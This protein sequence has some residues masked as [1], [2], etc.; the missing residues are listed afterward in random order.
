MAL[1]GA[2]LPLL[3]AAPPG[4]PGPAALRELGAPG[5]AAVRP[6]ALSAHVR[7]LSSDLLGGRGTATPGHAL[8]ELYVSAE[9]EAAGLEP[10]G[11]EG[12]WLQPVPLR[13]WR[14]DHASS[15]LALHG[16]SHPL[17]ALVPDEDFVL[18]SDGEHGEV[19]VDGPLAFA[20]YAVSAPEYGY[21]DLRG[22]DLRGKVAVVLHGAPLSERKNFFPPTAHALYSDRREKVRRL[23]E[24]GAVGVLF[25]HT[26]D[27]AESL[28]WED[29][30]RDSRTEGM[31]WLEGGRLG[32]GV[33]GV[34]ARGVLSAR[35][36]AKVLAAAGI[37]GGAKAVLEKAEANRLVPQEWMLRARFRSRAEMREARGANVLG[38]LRGSDPAL[39][40][41]VVVITA[42]LDHLGEGEPVGGDGIYNGAL[43]NASGVA[44]LIEAARAFAALPVR[45][46]RSLLFA[47]VT[48]EEKGL[49]GS[50]YLAL[51]LPVARERVVASLNVDGAPGPFPLE[52]AVARGAEHSTLGRA[53]QAAADALG[54]P[55][56]PDPV[57][58]AH[59]FVRS[60]QYSFVRIGVPAL[61]VG[62]GHQGA[63]AEARRARSRAR[64]HQPSDEW[65][66][67]WD[68]E[69]MARF[70]RLQF[71]TAL[72]VAQSPERPRWNDGDL[73][74]PGSARN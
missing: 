53:A 25:V 13:A 2:L 18:L 20:G 64:H 16:P 10:G 17:A 49:L 71:L 67:G 42:H 44:V 9:M 54:V 40:S 46:A 45:P 32:S 38:M 1:A 11:P 34:L 35:G 55:L 66:P 61:F 22:A 60:D 48:G 62:P 43:D 14:V 69:A 28:L 63:D 39:A 70:A 30:I 58:R 12:A 57:P 73:L 23:A 15:R 51:H 52:D 72:A 19:E 47:A 24:R 37:P 29:L 3:L 27:W 4:A 65:E 7:F 5:L 36:F 21:D 33:R 31:G 41:E 56:S 68:W 26:P 74:A 50:E 6:G 8:A 59:V